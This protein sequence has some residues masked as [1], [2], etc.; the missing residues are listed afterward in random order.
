MAA[1][2]VVVAAGAAAA[3]A[4]RGLAMTGINAALAAEVI[5]LGPRS[6][7]VVRTRLGTGVGVYARD[8]QERTKTP[9][10]CCTNQ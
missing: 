4:A 7:H 6:P 8:T 2:A 5:S 3:G 1:A 10:R 9:R